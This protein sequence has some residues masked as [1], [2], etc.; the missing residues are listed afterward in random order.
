MK[1]TIFI[2]LA[3]S[4]V[5]LA[6]SEDF[7]KTEAALSENLIRLHVVANSDSDEDQELKIKVRDAIINKCGNVFSE[8][9]DIFTARK[10]VCDNIE[11]IKK[12]AVEEIRKNGYDYDVNVC[13]TK[14]DF[15]TKEY[16]DLILPMGNY[17]ALKVEIGKAEGKNWWC[18]LFPPLCFVNDT[19][20]SVDED[21]I[22]AFSQNIGSDK[23]EFISKDKS[24]SVEFR[25]KA[26]EMW[27]TGKKKLAW[28]F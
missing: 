6:I 28:I 9:E 18:V 14:E 8:T 5:I 12:C 11:A 10:N 21:T 24:S 22:E 3:F 23:K 25:F 4:F 20:V 19:C 15:P 16:G 26:Y 13:I 2:F 17:E 27:Q 1:K 7:S